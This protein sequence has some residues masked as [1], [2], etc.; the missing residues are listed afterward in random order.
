MTKTSK[1]KP[2]IVVLDDMED[3]VAWLRSTVKGRATIL[4]ATTVNGLLKILKTAE[5]Q[6]GLC[7]VLLDHDL[8]FLNGRRDNCDK[9]GLCGTDAAKKLTLSDMSIP[10]VIWS[11]NG[12]CAMKME[13]ILLRRGFKVSRMMYHFKVILAGIINNILTPLLQKSV[14]IPEEKP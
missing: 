3:R 4:W 14:E 5:T 2:I 10:I 6:G 12:P 13:D 11:L 9:D 7:L 1:N 8:D